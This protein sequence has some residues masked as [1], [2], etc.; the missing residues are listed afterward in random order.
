MT[1]PEPG[2]PIDWVSGTLA[3]SLNPIL[4]GG[5]L[6][7][8]ALLVRNFNEEA[9]AEEDTTT[10]GDEIQMVILTFGILG[11]GNTIQDGVDLSGVISPTGYGEGYAAADRYRL[12]G[13]PMVRGRVRVEPTLDKNDL[14]LFTAPELEPVEPCPVGG[15]PE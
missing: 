7:C 13:K 6:A 3:P 8:K 11:D 15:F 2:G 12:D 10:E 1:D 5:L 9:F 4:K 14:A